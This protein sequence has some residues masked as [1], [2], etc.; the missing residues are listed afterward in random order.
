M[1]T[2]STQVET[3][4]TKQL[5]QILSFRLFMFVVLFLLEDLQL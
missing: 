5:K 2:I 4:S 1:E 3:N